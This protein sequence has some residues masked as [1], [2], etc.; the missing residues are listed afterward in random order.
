MNIFHVIHEFILLLVLF[1][2]GMVTAP[3][4][5]GRPECEALQA[6]ACRVRA[7]VP[8]IRLPPSLVQV[9]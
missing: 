1:F 4:P 3:S 6:P 2:D 7:T 8:G 5:G 9:F